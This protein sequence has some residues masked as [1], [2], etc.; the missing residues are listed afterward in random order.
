MRVQPGFWDSSRSGLKYSELNEI[1]NYELSSQSL[2]RLQKRQINK[3]PRAIQAQH[4]LSK[5]QMYNPKKLEKEV[6]NKIVSRVVQILNS[7]FK[8]QSVNFTVDPRYT[9]AAIELEAL[10]KQITPGLAIPPTIINRLTQGPFNKNS[11]DFY[12]YIQEKAAFF[13]QIAANFFT[14]TKT[15]GINTGKWGAVSDFNRQLITDIYVFLNQSKLSGGIIPYQPSGNFEKDLQTIASSSSIK[16][17]S[18]VQDFNKQLQK[19]SGTANIRFSIEDQI[20]NSMNQASLLRIQAK[21]GTNQSL[22]NK[23]GRNIISLQ[24]FQDHKLNLLS[25]LEKEARHWL[26][27]VRPIKSTSLDSYANYVLSKNIDKTSLVKDNNLYF[28]DLGFVTAA[29]W[30]EKKKKYLRFTKRVSL[31]AQLLQ[32][33]RSYGM[34]SI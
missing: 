1:N 15:T 25:L 24:E 6:A 13:E 14:G 8:S 19:L 9:N 17:N 18:N 4:I 5:L 12:S 28:T 3:D 27:K 10:L 29:E 11:N 23:N 33:N 32:A 20:L 7:P 31:N 16:I 21:S 22:L 30:M 2:Q 34:Y 26:Y